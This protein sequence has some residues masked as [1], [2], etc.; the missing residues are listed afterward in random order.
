LVFF[1][2]GTLRLSSE[3]CTTYQSIRHRGWA[4]KL[5]E[6]EYKKK[7]EAEK[8]CGAAMEP[9]EEEEPVEEEEVEDPR[10][11]YWIPLCTLQFEVRVHGKWY[12]LNG[13]REKTQWGWGSTT[14]S[15]RRAHIKRSTV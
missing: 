13:Q 4:A 2:A 10:W 1:S 12:S 5:Q 3:L 6:K 9:S 7:S 8:A 11:C 15:S 14:G